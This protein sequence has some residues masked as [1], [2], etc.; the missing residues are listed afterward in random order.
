MNNAQE[1][2]LW[3]RVANSDPAK[4]ASAL[5]LRV[6]T[7]AR[8]VSMAAGGDQIADQ[9]GVMEIAKLSHGCPARDAADSVHQ[10]VA[11][12]LRFNRAARPM[13]EYLARF[14]VLR[15][16]ADSEMRMGLDSPEVLA[17]CMRRA[18]L[19]WSEK[20]LVPPS[21]GGLWVF[22]PLPDTGAGFLG[23]SGSQ[24]DKMFWRR[25]MRM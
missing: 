11:C 18:S 22:L 10:E 23:I 12:L 24:F 25:R 17:I 9:E 13:D 2:E 14:D 21:F 16:N 8:E 5:F 7:A 6:D 3:R 15:R 1:V 20:S 19:S 4:R